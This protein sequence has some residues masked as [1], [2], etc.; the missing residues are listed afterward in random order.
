M[1]AVTLQHASVACRTNKANSTFP[2]KMHTGGGL[3][4]FL[5]DLTSAFFAIVQLVFAICCSGVGR[6]GR[7]APTAGAAHG[8]CIA[9]GAY[10]FEP[11]KLNA[12][13]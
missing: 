7:C 9:K 8:K 11:Q 1:F 3:A 12:E 6:K 10:A 4:F 5:D 2:L 13:Q